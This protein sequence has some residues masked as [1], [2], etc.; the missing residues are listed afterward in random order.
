MRRRGLPG[1][2]RRL[3]VPS[4]WD[5]TL[6]EEIAAALGMSRPATMKLID[7]AVALATRLDATAAAL[8]AG[9]VDYLKPRSSPRRPRC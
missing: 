3:G 1:T 5:D 2:A 9:E 7:L 4:A 8:A 6:T